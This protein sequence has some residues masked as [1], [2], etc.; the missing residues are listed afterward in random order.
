MTTSPPASPKPSAEHHVDR[1][2]GLG[3]VCATTT[4]LPAASPS[5]LTTI[6]AP[7]A[8]TIG[9]GRFGGVEALIGGGRDAVGAAQILGEALGAFQPGRG[10]ARAERLDAGSLKIVDDAGAK[11]RLRPDHDQIDPLLRQNAMTAAWS[12][13]S[14]G[15]AVGL[16]GDAG[17]ARR[18][19]KPVDQRACRHFPCQRMLA[20]TGA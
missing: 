8:R 4:P 9:L 19:I 14:S 6:G 12:A 13:I 16:P 11:R 1:R 17:I 7:C 2:F 5:A 15:D 18:A 10:A 20:P 3:E